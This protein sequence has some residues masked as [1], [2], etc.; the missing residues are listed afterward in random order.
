ME[1]EKA[2]RALEGVVKKKE[3]IPPKIQTTEQTKAAKIE[4]TKSL[5][6]GLSSSFSLD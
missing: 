6:Q 4:A 1:L 2:K 3:E 5:K